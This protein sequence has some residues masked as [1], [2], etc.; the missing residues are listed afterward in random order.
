MPILCVLR[1]SAVG[2]SHLCLKK[3]RYF[4]YTDMR[5]HLK[6][7][8]V[9]SA[10]LAMSWDVDVIDPVPSSFIS[11]V[12]HKVYLAAPFTNGRNHVLGCR[13]R[14]QSPLES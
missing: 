2:V 10:R 9:R 7:F 5:I 1:I 14:Q 11:Y 12:D 8:G 13:P 4:I 6:H 3:S